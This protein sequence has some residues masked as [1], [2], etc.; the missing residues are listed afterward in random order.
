MR[1]DGQLQRVGGAADRG[2][3]FGAEA[4]QLP[5]LVRQPFVERE[6]IE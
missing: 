6:C 5:H 1:D 3:Q 4:D 2:R